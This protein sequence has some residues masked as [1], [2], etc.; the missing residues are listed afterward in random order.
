MKA[1][2]EGDAGAPILSSGAH[3]PPSHN[4]ADRPFG[5]GSRA[6]IAAPG[7]NRLRQSYS[8]NCGEGTFSELRSMRVPGQTRPTIAQRGASAEAAAV[9]RA[10][11]GQVLL[12]YPSIDGG[13][14][15]LLP[16]SDASVFL[17]YEAHAPVL[18]DHDRHR[19][20]QRAAQTVGRAVA[21]THVSGPLFGDILA[22]EVQR[23][24]HAL[25]L[26]QPAGDHAAEAKELVVLAHDH[27]A[28]GRR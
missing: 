17:A 15:L 23:P 18:G 9:R 20:G 4:I 27:R 5:R 1:R 8:P 25:D 13:G 12:L 24:A 2:R 19:S 10:I 6:I 3:P 26:R 21:S 16:V 7:R 28:V 14:S 11:C 22:F